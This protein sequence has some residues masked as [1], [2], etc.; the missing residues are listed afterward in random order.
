[1][2]T[3][4]GT[5]SLSDQETLPYASISVLCTKDQD[6]TGISVRFGCATMAHTAWAVTISQ[7]TADTDTVRGDARVC[8]KDYII[9]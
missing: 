3:I 5:N 7:Y 6:T 9:T 8:T 2:T 1:M 4:R